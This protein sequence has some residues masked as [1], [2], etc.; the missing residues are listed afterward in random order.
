MSV[1]SEMNTLNRLFALCFMSLTT[2]VALASSE[3]VGLGPANVSLDLAN[4]GSYT[5]EKGE[6]FGIGA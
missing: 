2:I 3:T 4:A 1:W 5:V 6:S